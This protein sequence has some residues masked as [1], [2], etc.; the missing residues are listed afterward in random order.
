M[1]KYEFFKYNILL[2]LSCT[3]FVL[4][5]FKFVLLNSF[6]LLILSLASTSPVK[7]IFAILY[8]SITSASTL[9][10]FVFCY[11]YCRISALLCISTDSGSG[12]FHHIVHPEHFSRV[13]SQGS[14]P[15]ETIS[16][17][18]EWKSPMSF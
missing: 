7:Y 8:E 15:N 3:L 6:R 9:L 4:I 17:S 18:K 12:C 1:G 13:N 5:S 2:I 10:R 14:K 16:T 11:Y